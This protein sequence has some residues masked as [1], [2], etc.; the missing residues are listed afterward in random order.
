MKSCKIERNQSTT[1]EGL[2]SA[3]SLTI[4]NACEGT[5]LDCILC[6]DPGGLLF[7]AMPYYVNSNCCG[8]EFMLAENESES[9]DLE[10]MFLEYAEL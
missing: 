10:N 3:L 7:L 1:L 5:L 8:Y 2:I 4:V 6:T 9:L